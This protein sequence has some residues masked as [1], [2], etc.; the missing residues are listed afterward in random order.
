MGVKESKAGRGLC[1]PTIAS[2]DCSFDINLDSLFFS[3]E[4]II[5]TD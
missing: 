1:D 5:Q 3:R 2:D 4:D